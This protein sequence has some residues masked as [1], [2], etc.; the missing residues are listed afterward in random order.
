MPTASAPNA[1]PTSSALACCGGGHARHAVSVLEPRHGPQ[2]R[3]REIAAADADVDEKARPGRRIAQHARKRCCPVH[4]RRGLGDAAAIHGGKADAPAASRAP[5]ASDA[6]PSSV[7]SAASATNTLRH[8]VCVTTHASGAPAMTAPRLPANIVTPISVAKRFAR[9]PGGGHLE[10]RDERDRYADAD[11]RASGRGDFPGRREREHQRADPGDDRARSE[12]LARPERV[13][14]HAD[15]DLQ[16]RV[17]VEVGGRER[18]EDGRVDRERARKL[19]GDRRRRRAVKERKD[20]ACENDA[21]D[22]AAGADERHALIID[23]KRMR[24]PGTV[25]PFAIGSGSFHG[26]GRQD[27]A[28]P[29]REATIARPAAS[30]TMIASRLPPPSMV[31]MNLDSPIVS[32]SSPVPA[33]ASVTRARPRSSPKARRWRW[34]RAIA[35]ISMRRSSACRARSRSRSRSPPT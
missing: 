4:M 31:S 7:D 21:E 28:R 32:S 35:R 14:Q 33:K 6:M 30:A 26:L 16:D 8:E 29:E 11:Q 17:D 23:E 27:R 20:K 13:G 9:K 3:E 34:S 15:R 24:P 22:D 1:T 2:S 10:D 12:D 25:A 18:S 19:G 5:A